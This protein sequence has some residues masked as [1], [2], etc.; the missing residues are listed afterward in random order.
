MSLTQEQRRERGGHRGGSGP[1]LLVARPTGPHHTLEAAERTAR[2]TLF[3]SEGRYA[4]LHARG[5]RLARFVCQ[6]DEVRRSGLRGQS[7][8]SRIEPEVHRQVRLAVL[9]GVRWRGDRV[10]SLWSVQAEEHVRKKIL[11]N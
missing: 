2:R 8:W 4:G 1:G 6:S 3:L 10:K 5:L 7:G 11:G 9:V